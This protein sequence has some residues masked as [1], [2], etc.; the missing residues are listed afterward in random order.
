MFS[1]ELPLN[2]MNCLFKTFVHF[3]VECPVSLFKDVEVF[4]FRYSVICFYYNV[5]VFYAAGVFESAWYPL[6]Y[7]NF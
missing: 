7:I 4:V 6:L 1:Y 5:Y 3:S 2:S